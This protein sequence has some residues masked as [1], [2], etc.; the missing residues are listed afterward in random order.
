MFWDVENASK[1]CN[2]L[3][4]L[5]IYFVFPWARS[6]WRYSLNAISEQNQLYPRTGIVSLAIPPSSFAGLINILQKTQAPNLSRFPKKSA[7]YVP[8]LWSEVC[9]QFCSCILKKSHTP[10]LKALPESVAHRITLRHPWF[11]TVL[12]FVDSERD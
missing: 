7:K 10:L 1:L 3:W 2:T 4:D 6:H 12:P 5:G 8:F 11:S 9:F